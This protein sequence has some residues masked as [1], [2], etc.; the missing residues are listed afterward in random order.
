MGGKKAFRGTI[1]SWSCR[2][3]GAPVT[4]LVPR[5]DSTHFRTNDIL[6]VFVPTGIRWFLV[7][8]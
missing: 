2:E 4:P 3:Q 5:L 6:H 8:C 1:G 7:E